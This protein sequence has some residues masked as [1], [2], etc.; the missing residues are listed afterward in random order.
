MPIYNSSHF[1]L[2]FIS[3]FQRKVVYIDQWSSGPNYLSQRFTVHFR[4]HVASV[5]T[6]MDIADY[7]I[8]VYTRGNLDP[9]YHQSPFSNDCGIFVI[10][11]LFNL[12]C[13]PESID[14]IFVTQEHC[15]TL[16]RIFGAYLFSDL[17]R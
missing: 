2:A 14:N 17:H 9:I 1:T 5:F 10:A 6:N 4:D 7:T 15:Y 3:S 13:L 11:R 8:E 16:R 12:I